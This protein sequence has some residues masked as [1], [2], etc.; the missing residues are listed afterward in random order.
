MDH[1]KLSIDDV[2]RHEAILDSTD[3]IKLLKLQGT[4]PESIH[5]NAIGVE[6]QEL[7]IIVTWLEKKSS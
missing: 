1:R 2:I 7:V 4:I 3:I 5:G 6:F